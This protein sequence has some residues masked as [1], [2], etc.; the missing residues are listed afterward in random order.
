[1]LFSDRKADTVGI[2][3]SILCVVHC[4]LLPVLVFA[5]MLNEEW[6]AHAEWVDYIFMGL[7]LSAVYYAARNAGLYLRMALWLTVSW[8]CASIL[9]HDVYE[10]ALYSSMAA[11]IVL[12]VLH[13]INFK[14][15]RL[16]HRTKEVTV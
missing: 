10:S 1:M 6:G 7:A 14:Q 11:S 5:G 12:V 9:L 3:S 2:V 13:T 16:L 8:F 15:H 4:M